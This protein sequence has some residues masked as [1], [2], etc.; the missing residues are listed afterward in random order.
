M[1]NCGKNQARPAGSEAPMTASRSAAQSSADAA[2]ARAGNHST[3]RIGPPRPAGQGGEQSFALQTGDGRTQSFGSL[4]EARAERA[5][6][7]G[8]TIS[9]A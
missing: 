5:R 7:G 4:L 6:S 8:G 2:K 1:C 9:P 3:S